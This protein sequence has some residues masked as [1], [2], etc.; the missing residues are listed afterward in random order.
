MRA[1]T[2]L[3]SMKNGHWISTM[4]LLCHYAISLVRYCC[5]VLDTSFKWPLTSSHVRSRMWWTKPV[6]CRFSFLIKAV[7]WGSAKKVIN[8]CTNSRKIRQRG[9]NF[10][11]CGSPVYSGGEFGRLRGRIHAHNSLVQP[12]FSFSFLRTY[13]PEE[14]GEEEEKIQMAKLF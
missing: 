12:W 9:T 8:I 1:F 3:S 10:G 5:S 14:E 6:H 4:N 11:S 13:C 7:Y 2:A